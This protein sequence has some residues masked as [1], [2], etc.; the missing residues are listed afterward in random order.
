MVGRRTSEPAFAAGPVVGAIA[1]TVGK[2]AAEA[3]VAPRENMQ[4]A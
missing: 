1:G 4:A 2:A 3:V